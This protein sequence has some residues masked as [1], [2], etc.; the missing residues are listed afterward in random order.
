MSVLPQ[1]MPQNDVLGVLERCADG[2]EGK[3]MT[4]NELV[5]ESNRIE[6]IR[7]APTVAD[8]RVF[9]NFLDLD[10]VTVG[11]LQNFVTLCA[12]G[13]FL[14]DRVGMNVCVG[15]HTPPRGGS[16]IRGELEV[17]LR[18]CNSLVPELR[19]DVAY[20]IHLQYERL[21][22]FMDG[23]GRSGRV[24]WYWMMQEDPI[25]EKLGFLHTFYYQTL[26][27]MGKLYSDASD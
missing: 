20:D 21:H 15:N 22:P 5:A 2:T 7:R 3:D 19:A 27:N 4:N 10:E 25:A 8:V 14:R 6:G 13:A 9:E 17:L 1:R 12:P 11:D 16:Y 23:N 26:E 18:V 24:L